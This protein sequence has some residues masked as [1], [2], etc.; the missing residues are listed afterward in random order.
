M[1][2]E[3][4]FGLMNFDK[5]AEV[6]FSLTSA[7]FS[8]ETLI[9]LYLLTLVGGILFSFE[10]FL[11]KAYRANIQATSGV[12]VD[13]ELKAPTE[14]AITGEREVLTPDTIESHLTEN[15]DLKGVNPFVDEV[16]K[17]V[18]FITLLQI[19]VTLPFS[20]IYTPLMHWLVNRKVKVDTPKEQL[21]T[22]LQLYYASNKVT[23]VLK[24]LWTVVFTILIIVV[25]V[26]VVILLVVGVF[27]ISFGG[28]L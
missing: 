10:Y 17:F 23:A 11:V 18:T 4:I 28:E 14:V 25:I 5:I 2:L 24:W 20:I 8:F 27:I 7:F 1:S 13:L 22:M 9:I 15:Q 6:F 12:M 21:N 26:A 19:I 16:D 3:T